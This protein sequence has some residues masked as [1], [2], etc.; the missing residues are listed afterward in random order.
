LDPQVK[1]IKDSQAS[2]KEQ[3]EQMFDSIAHRYDF[4]NHFLSVGIDK[5]WRRTAVESLRGSRPERILDVATGTGD[6]AFETLKRLSPKE[7]VGVDL[8]EGMLEKAR[9]KAERKNSGEIRF[10][11]GDSENLAFGDNIFDAVTVAFGVRNFGDLEKG[12][13][14]IYR[15]LKPGGKLVVLEFSKPVAFPVKQ[16]Y[17]FYFKRMLPVAGRLVSK[18]ATAYTYLPASVQ[19]FPEGKRFLDILNNLGYTQCTNRPLTFGICSLYTGL[20]KA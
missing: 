17:N 8:S 18:D 4:L 7:I 10:L 5:R 11:K 14:E 16:L 19:A 6:F 9:A 12:L 13:S 2:K 15:V 3:V 20:K 1:P